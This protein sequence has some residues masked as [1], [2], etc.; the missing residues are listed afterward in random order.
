MFIT[1]S[2]QTSWWPHPVPVHAVFPSR[3]L[4]ALPVRA[5]IEHAGT[6]MATRP[7]ACGAG[8]KR[9]RGGPRN[10]C[11][12]VQPPQPGYHRPMPVPDANAP[13]F[14]SLYAELRR[15][16][17]RELFKGGE[18]G[19]MSPTTLLHEAYLQ[20]SARP[21]LQFAD[22][23]HFL[24][25]AARVLPPL[26][27]IVG[28]Y[29]FWVG[30]DDPGGKFQGATILAAMWLL[31]LMAGLA[32]APP[33]SRTWLRVGLV[34]GPLVFIAVGLLGLY[35]AG[36]F[37]GYPQGLA[38]PLI[39]AIELALLPSLTLVLALLLLGA[40]RRGMPT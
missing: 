26:G 2:G 21:G 35:A 25:Y 22:R 14:E 11:P 20:M 40:P 13:S 1:G 10:I 9:N 17:R 30:A 12:A 39:V 32:D 4:L 38:K 15:M 37:L 36:D 5:F 29:I 8:S 24:A 16:A 6:A 19:Q 34:A 18:V 23:A 28:T 33:I 7:M 3:R 31:V 27:I